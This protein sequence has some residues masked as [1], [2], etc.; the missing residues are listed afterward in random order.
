[1]VR[2]IHKVRKR[3]T[4]PKRLANGSHT[5]SKSFNYLYIRL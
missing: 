5:D 1:M 3:S 2:K 4:N